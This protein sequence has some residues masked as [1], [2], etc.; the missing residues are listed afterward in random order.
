[1]LPTTKPV[2][3]NLDVGAVRLPL[4]AEESPYCGPAAH[5]KYQNENINILNPGRTISGWGRLVDG[6][7][8]GAFVAISILPKTQTHHPPIFFL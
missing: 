4:Q 1:M 8:A 7:E 3:T 2:E 6:H 5:W